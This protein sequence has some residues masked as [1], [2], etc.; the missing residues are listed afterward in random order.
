MPA[1]RPHALPLLRALG[2]CLLVF[3]TGVKITTFG[4]KRKPCAGVIRESS[5]LNRKER[6][7]RKREARQPGEV[8][9]WQISG[10]AV[11]ELGGTELPSSSPQNSAL[12][13]FQEQD[14]QENQGLRL[15][16]SPFSCLRG[17]ALKI[18]SAWN[19]IPP[20]SPLFGNRITVD[21]IS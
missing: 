3:P 1:A 8:G 14:L 19:V 2:A 21:E 5:C 4:L 15:I 18:P 7:R 17:F 11:N 6:G 16:D 13:F 20:P 10:R 12:S 9:N